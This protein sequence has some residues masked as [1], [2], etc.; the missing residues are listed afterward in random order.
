LLPKA[1]WT[2]R[3]WCMCTQTNFNN[4]LHA[5]VWIWPNFITCTRTLAPTPN[6]DV[7][8]SG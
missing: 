2:L 6:Y 4:S 3:P 1:W 8:R 7:S 5:G